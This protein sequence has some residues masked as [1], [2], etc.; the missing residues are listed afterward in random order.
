MRVRKS[1][2]LLIGA[3]AALSACKNNQADQNLAMNNNMTADI[4]ALP[5]DESSE[6]PTNQL[7]NGADNPDVND[8][9][10][11]SSSY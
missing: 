2:L 9:A 1:T 8:L 5:P 3:A 11:N 7:A 6:T 10:N 4:E